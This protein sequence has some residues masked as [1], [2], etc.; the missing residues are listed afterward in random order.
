MKII[1]KLLSSTSGGKFAM[2]LDYLKP[3]RDA[4]INPLKKRG[5]EGVH[6]AIEVMKAYNLLRED[7]TNLIELSQW[8]DTKNPFND[9]DV[10]VSVTYT[11]N[12]TF[13]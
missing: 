2:N 13:R 12:S 3:L 8:K 10:K 4:I 11:Q 1:F 6:E 7:L 9:V 5:L